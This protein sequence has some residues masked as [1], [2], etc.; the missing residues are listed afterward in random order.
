MAKLALFLL[1]SPRIELGD[2]VIYMNTRKATALAAYL[3]VTAVSHRRDTLT[4]LL[5]PE[6]N[7]KRSRAAL[8]TTLS[9]FKKEVG[10]EW[11]L[12]VDDTISLQPDYWC[13]VIQFQQVVTN[14][15]EQSMARLQEA[16]D[17]YQDHFLAGFSLSDSATFDDW[18]YFQ[19]DSLRQQLGTT[20]QHLSAAYE[21]KNLAEQAITQCRRWLSL[22]PLHEPAHQQLMRLYAHSGQK[23][24]SL[25]Q[26]DQ[27]Q[28]ILNEELGI[29]PSPQ[30]IALYENIK[31]GSTAASAPNPTTK[32][33]PWPD[34][35]PSTSFVGRQKELSQIQERLADPNCRLLTL[36]GPGGVGKTRLALQTG[37]QLGSKTAVFVSLASILPQDEHFISAIADAVGFQ[38]Y[39]QANTKIQ[40][41]NF[42]KEKEWVLV[43][44]NF[45]HLQQCKPILSVLLQHAHKIKLLVTSRERLNLQG[46]WLLEIEGLPYPQ[47]AITLFQQR[48]RQLAPN[49]NLSDQEEAIVHICR[50]VQGLPLGIE[51]AAAWVRMLSCQQIAVEIEQNVDFLTTQSS[52]M[53]ARHRSLRA[54]FNH[55]WQLLDEA[56]QRLYRQLAVFPAGFSR[57]TAVAVLAVTLPQLSRLVDKSLL[58]YDYINRYTIPESLYPFVNGHL[59]SNEDEAKQA[60]MAHVRFFATFMTQ[61]SSSIRGGAQQKALA[62]ITH[63]ID[64]VR[65]AWAWATSQMNNS[66]VGQMVDPLARFYEMRNFFAEGLN[67][68]SI[69]NNWSEENELSQKIKA[70]GLARYGRF[71]HRLGDIEQAHSCAQQSLTLARKLGL[72]EDIAFALNNLGYIFWSQGDYETAKKYYEESLELYRQLDNQWGIG[73]LLN[74]LAILPQALSET[75]NLLRESLS[76]ARTLGDAWGEARLLNNLGFA[77]N[78]RTESQRLWQACVTLC[79]QLEDQYLLTFPLINLGHSARTAGQFEQARHYYQE[80]F[81]VC[82]EL[83]YQQ[84]IA[85]NWGHLGRAAY[86][87]GEYNVAIQCCQSGLDYAQALS[88]QRGMGLLYFTLGQVALAMGNMDTAVSHLQYSLEIFRD[89]HDRQGEA[90]PLLGIAE[91]HLHHSALH[92]THTKAHEALSIFTDVGDKIGVALAHQL[93]ARSIDD[94]GQSRDHLQVALDT[95]VAQ[96]SPP[97]IMD[98]LATVA[99]WHFQVGNMQKAWTIANFISE[100]ETVTAVTK[101][102]A[103]TLANELQNST[104]N[105]KLSPTLEEL[106]ATIFHPTP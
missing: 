37:Q 69:F 32:P 80:S 74:H 45:E 7:Q 57:E 54:V 65:S 86:N 11:L 52:D 83:G 60:R 89:A 92:D 4:A 1:G 67:A 77:V 47:D 96:Q 41:F 95:A 22:D 6:L 59:Q 58:R 68:F 5:W 75:E 28:Q 66:F 56:E 24:A 42:L 63:E 91:Y 98:T 61:Q 13:D 23:A 99:E 9:V 8:R 46:E 17:L 44:D 48:A 2:Q 81:D 55:S 49:L 25:R 84:G 14:P 3:G 33:L 93:L 70:Q 43:L 29:S 35:Y 100:Q 27:L 103:H 12:A 101:A 40:L 102:K 51:L 97:L 20:L 31:R 18:Q 50:L 78:D 79:Q 73:Q 21:A 104:E 88:D 62:T 30:T 64:N 10:P 76:I 82:L 85:R 72:D 36:I 106:L 39:S 105:S 87:L 38:F 15:A 34:L 26:F 71:C 16:A 94:D 53:P 19:T 90:W